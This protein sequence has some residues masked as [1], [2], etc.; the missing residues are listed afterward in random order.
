MGSKIDGP[1]GLLREGHR[2]IEIVRRAPDH[3]PSLAA[4]I[5]DLPLTTAKYQG[6]VNSLLLR[7]NQG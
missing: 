4:T 1:S 2:Q 7:F 3:M 5:H 6:E